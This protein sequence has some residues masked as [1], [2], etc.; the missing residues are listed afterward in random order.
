MCAHIVDIRND[1]N[2][3]KY[4]PAVMEIKPL[5]QR[6][7]REKKNA[8]GICGFIDVLTS[9]ENTP[10]IFHILRQSCNQRKP[11]QGK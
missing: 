8:R 2:Q 1:S 7:G 5:L 10:N 9:L 4:K 3:S 11:G 6:K